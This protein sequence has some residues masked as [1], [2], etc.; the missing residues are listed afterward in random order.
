MAA[1]APG[2]ATKAA[3]DVSSSAAKAA[4]VPPIAVMFKSASDTGTAI[5]QQ[6]EVPDGVLLQFG[7]KGSYRLPQL[8]SF[9]DW[10]MPSVVTAAETQVVVLDWFAPH[11]DP[12]VDDAMRQKNHSVLRIGGGLTGDVQVGDTHRHGP[13]SKAYR[14]AETSDAARELRLRPGRLPCVS[15]QTV[16]DRAARSW[17]QLLVR[18]PEMEWKEN[19]ILNDRARD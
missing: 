19:G 1:G 5:R 9:L 17:K 18:D 8:L 13:Y 14:A 2:L 7:P 16:L 10:A 3:A 12:M 4:D 6:L 11:I 15:R